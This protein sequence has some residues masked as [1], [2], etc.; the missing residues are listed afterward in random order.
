MGAAA[1]LLFGLAFTL[2]FGQVSVRLETR[3]S[4]AAMMPLISS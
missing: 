1:F 3:R 2:A 4:H